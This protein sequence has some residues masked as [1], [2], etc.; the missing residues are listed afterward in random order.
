MRNLNGC[1]REQV[2]AYNYLFSYGHI[3]EWDVDHIIEC[4]NNNEK[5]KQKRLNVELIKQCIR[6]NYDQYI[7][8]PFI[9]ADYETIRD[10][11]PIE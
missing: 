5:L 4:V 1:K 6:K 10:N 2:I 3:N 11:L 7:K 8:N 9:A